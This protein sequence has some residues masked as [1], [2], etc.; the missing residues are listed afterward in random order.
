MTIEAEP[1]SGTLIVA[2]DEVTFER[3]EA[4]L[5]DL[6][7]VPRE[8]ELAIVPIAN[9]DAA[10]VGERALSIYK[11]QV[12][13][14]PGAGEVELSVNESTNALEIVC[15]CGGVGAFSWRLGPAAGPG[16][17]AA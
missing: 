4:L 3:V 17:P 11:A 6:S 7:A 5:E 12:A 14:V 8:R 2:G 1:R 16:R 9:A 10:A 13:G 15:R